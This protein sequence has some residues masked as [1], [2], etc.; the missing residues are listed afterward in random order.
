[1]AAVNWIAETFDRKGKIRPYAAARVSR[2]G[3]TTSNNEAYL[4]G[5]IGLHGECLAA[6][7]PRPSATRTRSCPV[8][9]LHAPHHW[10]MTASNPNG[11]AVGGWLSDLQG[12]PP[13]HRLWRR[14][15]PWPCLD[16][17]NFTPMPRGRRRPVHARGTR[18]LDVD[19][20]KR[21]RP[22]RSAIIKEQVERERIRSS[23]PHGPGRSQCRH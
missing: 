8:T 3:A 18:S 12:C 6:F 13:T 4:A 17:M 2:A 19:K 9:V 15:W 21:R 20:L 5:S 23:E 1:V 11:G 10:P 16:P 7:M 14:N 22:E